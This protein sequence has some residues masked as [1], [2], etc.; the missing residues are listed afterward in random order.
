MACAA[1]SNGTPTFFVNDRRHEG[2]F[3]IETLSQAINKAAGK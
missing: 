2:D 1:G 3:G